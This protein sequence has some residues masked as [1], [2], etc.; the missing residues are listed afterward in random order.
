M[1]VYDN[2]KL[3]RREFSANPFE[4]MCCSRSKNTSSYRLDE[5][6][7]CGHGRETLIA[8]RNRDNTIR[9]SAGTG[10]ADSVPTSQ[11]I[12]ANH[13]VAGT[14]LVPQKTA[15][16]LQDSAASQGSRSYHECHERCYRG[17]QCKGGREIQS[18]NRQPLLCSW[19]WEGNNDVSSHKPQR[20]TDETAL[21]GHGKNSKHNFTLLLQVHKRCSGRSPAALQTTTQ[22]HGR[23]V[24]SANGCV[25]NT[26]NYLRQTTKQTSLSNEPLTSHISHIFQQ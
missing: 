10:S 14:I 26:N 22:A 18:G 9:M 19:C 3:L 11:Q 21:R 25:V 12:H 16:A 23:Q 4:H 8:S 7:S 20:C 5:H 17:M 24:A 2:H 6:T 15:S 13:L 1:S